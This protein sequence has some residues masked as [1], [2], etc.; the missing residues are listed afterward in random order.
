MSTSNIVNLIDTIQAAIPVFVPTAES[1]LAVGVSM[2][3]PN[4]GPTIGA[5]MTV[6]NAIISDLLTLTKQIEPAIVSLSAGATE[7]S[8][9][10][11]VHV[12]VTSR[13][14]AVYGYHRL[15]GTTATVPLTVK[16][17]A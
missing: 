15:S 12:G 1:I 17:S 5:D 7:P 14:V 4:L 16:V 9:H 2:F 11:P 8:P 3:D 10:A 13:G 6:A